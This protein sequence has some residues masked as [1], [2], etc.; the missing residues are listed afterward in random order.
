MTIQADNFTNNTLSGTAVVLNQK[1]NISLPTQKIPLEGDKTFTLK[2]RQTSIA[3]TVLAQSP[4]ITLKDYSEIVSITPNVSVIAEGES[5]RFDIVTAN[6]DDNSNIYYS[7]AGNA[8]LNDVLESNTGVILITSNSGSV[9]FTANV[10]LNETYVET[11]EIIELQIRNRAVDG[12]IYPLQAN[13]VILDTSNVISLTSQI[14]SSEQ[15]IESESV[16]LSLDTIN[17]LGNAGGTLYYTITGNANIYSDISGSIIINDNVA[18]LEIISESNIPDSESRYFIIEI[19]KNSTSGPVI[20]TSNTITVDAETGSV[21]NPKISRVTS[22]TSNVETLSVGESILFTINTEAATEGETLYYS[23]LGNVDVATFVGGNTGSFVVSANTGTVELF[24]N[25]QVEDKD[26]SLNVLR[27]QD[28][29]V[30]NSSNTKIIYTTLFVTLSGGTT[31]S[32]GGYTYHK[33][34]S[35]ANLIVSP[36]PSSYISSAEALIVAGGGSGGGM[37]GWGGGGGGGAG[38]ITT[39]PIDR[40]LSYDDTLTISVGAGGARQTSAP[41]S[42]NNGTPSTIL[43]NNTGTTLVA[44][45]GGGGARETNGRPGGSGGGGAGALVSGGS[46]TQPSTGGT[47]NPTNFTHYGFAGGGVGPGGLSNY[48]GAGGG[49]SGAVGTGASSTG[50]GPGGTGTDAFSVWATAT[51]SGSGGRYGGGGGGTGR[52]TSPTSNGTGGAGGGGAGGT[53]LGGGDATINTGS[54]GGGWWGPGT[55]AVTVTGAGGGAGGSG[56]VIIRYKTTSI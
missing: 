23:I 50:G 31:Y 24:A 40:L 3:G 47:N 46:A 21:T 55:S 39:G 54:G 51:S 29:V 41:Q 38:G 25:A 11:D 18:N 52:A 35:T 13:A 34:L 22:V 45:G 33:F 42:G 17:A 28:G 37:G 12:A 2:V 26:F 30:L 7:L 6:I 16:V 49:G 32:S 20:Y 44:Y 27:Q 15:I 1:I 36:S 5:V 56:I 4:Q 19:R 53:P 48:R 10:D 9:V 43:F 8:I 14:L